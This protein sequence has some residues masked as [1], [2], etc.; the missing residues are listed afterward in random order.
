MTNK[1]KIILD[2]LHKLWKHYAA[3]LKELYQR[4]E[5]IESAKSIKMIQILK[6]ANQ[7]WLKYHARH[8]FEPKY[9]LDYK[10]LKTINDNTLL[11]IMPNGKERKTNLKMLN[12]AVQ[13][14]L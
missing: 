7:S 11:L 4:K 14:S 9:L 2:E 12:L 10:V 1:G 5:Y 13:Q 3:H 8:T 6:L